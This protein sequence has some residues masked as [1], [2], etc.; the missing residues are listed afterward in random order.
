[1]IPTLKDEVNQQVSPAKSKALAFSEVQEKY[2]A[3]VKMAEGW[4][5]KTQAENLSIFALFV[6]VMGDLQVDQMDRVRLS[7]YKSILMQLPPNLNKKPQYKDLSIDEIIASKPKDTIAVTTLNKYIRRLSGLFN[8]AVRN[9]H[10]SL[11]PAEGMQLSALSQHW[12]S[13]RSQPRSRIVF[14]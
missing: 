13:T 5:E 10:M 8:Y 9:G 2:I 4:T 3:E 12:L 1:M 7:E 6:R 14:Q 11:N